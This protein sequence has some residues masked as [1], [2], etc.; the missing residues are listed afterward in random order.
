VFSVL[1]YNGAILLQAPKKINKTFYLCDKIFHLDQILEMFKEEHCN[2]IVFVSGKMYAFYKVTKSGEHL[3]IKKVIS[4]NVDLPKGHNKGGQSACRFARLRE[5]AHDNYINKLS[6][7][8]IKYFMSNNNTE[9]LI[10]KLIIAGP[11]KKKMQLADNVLVQQYLKNK[12]E[13]ITTSNL[14]DDTIYNIINNTTSIF[15][16][17]KDKYETKIIEEIQNLLT[18]NPDKLLFGQEEIMEAYNGF[19][20]EKIIICEQD[21]ETL[22]LDIKSTQIIRIS[23]NKLNEIGFNMVGVKW[24]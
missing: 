20:L 16:S 21:S 6:E 1:N 2:G 15:D 4:D 8:V 11:S 10:D 13:L 5:A 18:L 17:E 12:I 23:S 9:Y 3:G 7:L 24:Y 22:N 19:E 14:N